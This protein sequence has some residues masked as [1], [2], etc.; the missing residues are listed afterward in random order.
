MIELIIACVETDLKDHLSHSDYEPLSTGPV[1]L[2]EP[3]PFESS[4]S[5]EPERVRGSDCSLQKTSPFVDYLLPMQ[6]EFSNTTMRLNE[7]VSDRGRNKKEYLNE[8]CKRD[9][10]SPR[11]RNLLVERNRRN[12]L[13]ANILSLR[14]LVPTITKVLLLQNFQIY[15]PEFV[16]DPV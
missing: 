6:F 2:M 11:S 1:S 3:L 4:L 15:F 16:I 14:S 12:K 8:L 9:R 13:K 10:F 5:Y 7:V